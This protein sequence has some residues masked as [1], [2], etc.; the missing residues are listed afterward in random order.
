ML[1]QIKINDLPNGNLYS[2][3]GIKIEGGDPNELFIFDKERGT[4]MGDNIAYLYSFKGTISM[5]TDKGAKIIEDLTTEID[6]FLY[7]YFFGDWK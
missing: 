3:F 5:A 1:S 6:D 7:S 2:T 4:K